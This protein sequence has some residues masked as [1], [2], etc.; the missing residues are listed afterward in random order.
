MFMCS[1]LVSRLKLMINFIIL[2]TLDAFLYALQAARTEEDMK[3]WISFI[4][5]H[6]AAV[7]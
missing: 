2:F 4:D 7:E 5:V 3:Q 1:L 6:M